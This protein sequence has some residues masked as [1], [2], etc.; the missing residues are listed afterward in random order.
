MKESGIMLFSGECKDEYIIYC[1]WC[2]L[3]DFYDVVY[4]CFCVEYFENVVR[5]LMEYYCGLN[6]EFFFGY[7]DWK[8]FFGYIY[9]DIQ[10][11]VFQ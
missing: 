2:I 1:N 3:E 7:D 4:F 11:Y 10:V 9:V 6:K 8:V 5:K